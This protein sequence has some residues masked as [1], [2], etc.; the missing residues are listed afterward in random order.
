MGTS[1]VSGDCAGRFRARG[2]AV[3]HSCG[4]QVCL[5]DYPM[6]LDLCV[7]PH[8]YVNLGDKM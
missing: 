3:V 4:G 8:S 7:W 2:C 6:I 5:R 1:L